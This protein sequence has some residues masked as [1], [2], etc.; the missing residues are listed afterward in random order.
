MG[1]K[2]GAGR[3][4]PLQQVSREEAKK[5][6]EMQPKEAHTSATLAGASIAPDLLAAADA[7]AHPQVD[8]K[9]S[10][11]APAKNTPLNEKAAAPIEELPE[12]KGLAPAPI[13][14][15]GAYIGS[16]RPGSA[17]MTLKPTGMQVYW[18]LASVDSSVR[19]QA[20]ATLV[21]ELVK[22]QQA[23]ENRDGAADGGKASVRGCAPGVQYALR[24]LVRGLG[25]GN[26][27]ARQGFALA[28]SQVLNVVPSLSGDSLLEL[29]NKELDLSASAKGQDARDV[30][31]GRI[32]AYGAI[33]RSPYL[34]S[35]AQTEEQVH[36][37][38]A[39]VQATL[40]L[41]EKKSFLRECAAQVAL[42]LLHKLP[43]SAVGQLLSA[44]QSALSLWLSS[45]E[46]SSPE[47]LLLALRL[48]QWGKLSDE[49]RA[50]IALLPSS[51]LVQD[52]FS[53]PHL[54]K[55][56]EQLKGASHSHPRLHSVWFALSELLLSRFD[57]GSEAAGKK[58]K[59]TKKDSGEKGNGPAGACGPTE[60]ASLWAVV[61]EGGLLQSKSH[62]RKVLAME[63]LR[64]LLLPHLT[65]AHAPAVLSVRFL[66]C[67]L[68][69]LRDA[70]SLLHSEARHL[71]QN[72]LGWVASGEDSSMRRVALL[73]ALQTQ[74]GGAFDK[75]TKTDTVK[76]L[77]EG[78]DDAGWQQY[79]SSLKADFLRGEKDAAGEEADADD[80][81]STSGPSGDAKRL[82]AL[83]QMVAV[84]RQTQGGSR[85]RL[86]VVMDTARFLAAAG[87]FEIE[88]DG[89]LDELQG[90]VNKGLLSR[91][92]RDAA[93]SRML[94]LLGEATSNVGKGKRAP[95]GADGESEEKAKRDPLVELAEFVE[96]VESSSGAEYVRELLDEDREALVQLRGL[97]KKI[98]KK[99]ASAEGPVVERLSSLRALVIHLQLATLLEPG[100]AGEIATELE[101][102]Y[103]GAFVKSKKAEAGPPYMDV[104]VDV[105]LSLLARPSAAVR[106]AVDQVFKAFSSDLTPTGL[107]DLLRVLRRQPGSKRWKKA[108]DAKSE[109]ADADEDSDADEDVLSEEDDEE[110]EEEGGDE[111]AAEEG[112][113]SDE[114]GEEA[115]PLQIS[116][117]EVEADSDGEGG[118]GGGGGDES[119]EFSDMDD[120]TMFRVDR[121]LAA[122]LR[123]TKK[124]KQR[125]GK[126]GERSRA[127]A[128][129]HFQYRVLALLDAF[130][131]RHSERG[132]VLAAVL[133]LV[134]A[135]Q[136]A[137]KAGADGAPLADKIQALLRSRFFEG[138]P[139]YP[140]GAEVDTTAVRELL[141]KAFKHAASSHNGKVAAA[142][143]GAGLYF[144]KVLNGTTPGLDRTGDADVAA[145]FRATF[146]AFFARRSRLSRAFFG[147]AF[148]R[149]PWLA[150]AMAGDLLDQCEAARSEFLRTEAMQLLAAVLKNKASQPKSGRS[151]SD[152]P[153]VSSSVCPPTFPEALEPRRAQLD[154][155]LAAIPRASFT[156]V[157]RKAEALKFVCA[158][159]GALPRLY[160]DSELQQLV[161]PG[162]IIG[163]AQ[164]AK[165][166]DPDAKKLT[167]L[168]DN[169]IAL[170]GAGKKKGGKAGGKKKEGKAGQ[171][172]E[173]AGK[174]GN[175]QE[176]VE[177]EKGGARRKEVVV[178]GSGGPQRGTKRGL[179]DGEEK[180]GV[181]D[182]MEQLRAAKA[183][184]VGTASDGQKKGDALA[185]RGSAV[186][187]K[188][189][190]GDVRRR[191]KA[192]AKKGASAPGRKEKVEQ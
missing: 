22:D 31:L 143:G 53:V 178:N 159:L 88:A 169:V 138:G 38:G 162:A 73:T 85:D 110:E 130:L 108:A 125:S 152:T 42:E 168:L 136:R 105:L 60:L 95:V 50:Q 86:R 188:K 83:D 21:S 171:G 33:V 113:E 100:S 116:D 44:D 70:N 63:L 118:S 24:R 182:R 155:L 4:R 46:G 157:A 66:R 82:W 172:K 39:L 26:K 90:L 93:A 65:A 154:H 151:V 10:K 167:S 119:E 51:G 71:L 112:A 114:G 170:A 124:E 54:E 81:P 102:I 48:W 144:I 111:G 137:I 84:C 176:E 8:T 166:A 164:K 16:A 153:P 192:V 3:K 79:L 120:D 99:L 129:R 149:H 156:K 160:P 133:P 158:A 34:V 145:A 14:A 123:E 74:S 5:K 61:V 165:E 78:M 91:S 75:V 183:A 30:Y 40:E 13:N 62:E 6:G 139:K 36:L 175:V 29:I 52:L 41:G 128:A 140:R 27:G 57:S 187:R 163:A 20:A 98:E 179:A 185:G 28:L 43:A 69:S 55:L 107:A 47:S 56:L 37:A 49:A 150:R 146:Q 9:P 190:S 89:G 17:S 148:S 68:D 1:A 23:S 101:G 134:S 131:K 109:G 141:A 72:L 115:G 106:D 11:K 122:V 59:K 174:G 92:V 135:L 189:V 32:F 76:K 45:S 80:A 104:L 147:E 97:T 161:T 15:G 117:D 142:A 132:L 173:G 177:V 191:L 19:E 35:A 12:E 87:L 126:A 18:N 77:K 181:A 7:A 180:K 127:E 58:N 64:A 2:D 186:P 25:S 67:I 94:S 184:K 96:R 121:A 103:K